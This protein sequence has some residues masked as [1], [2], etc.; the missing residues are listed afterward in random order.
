MRDRSKS[1][2]LLKNMTISADQEKMLAELAET[3]IP[4]TST[5]G[6]AAISAH[7]FALKML[8]DC[9]TREQ[10]QKFLKGMQ[11]LDV[12][13]RTSYGTD[14]VG[15]GPAQREALLTA[16]ETNQ[17]AGDELTY[18]YM[19]MKRLTIQAYTSSR[20]FLTRVHVY[21]LVP[22]R[23]HGCVPVTKEPVTKELNKAS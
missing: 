6:A 10:Q 12:A 5:P 9:Y 19:E 2:I 22:G 11:Q 4:A 20:F 23:W 21:E 13:A 18:G 7:L 16:I 15:S 14:F 17:A 8:D 1:A 3:I